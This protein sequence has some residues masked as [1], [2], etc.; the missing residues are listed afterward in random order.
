MLQKFYDWMMAKASDRHATLWLAAFAFM[1]SSF[2]PIPPDIM[3]IPMV[4]ARRDRWLVLAT[5][6]TVSSVIGGFLGYAIG[7]YAIDLVGGYFHLAEKVQSMKP[8]VDQY[9]VWM[10][11]VKGWIPIIPY[12][13]VTITAGVFHFD[14]VKFAIASVVVRGAMR[15]YLVAGLFWKYGEPIRGFVE[16]RLKLVTAGVALAVVGGFVA[17]KFL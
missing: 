7:F 14:L 10:I 13:I 5:I 16:T 4:I 17:L 3:L 8:W 2:F 6:C 15:F 11:L 9:G 1:E 12:K